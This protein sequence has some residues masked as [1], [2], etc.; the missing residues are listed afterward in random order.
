VEVQVLVVEE[1]EVVT[2]EVP[3]EVDVVAVKD[4]VVAVVDLEE[5]EVPHEALQGV[6]LEVVHPKLRVWMGVMSGPSQPLVLERRTHRNLHLPI[7]FG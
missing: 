2:E 4:E 6:V 1:D 7:P 5:D 3:G